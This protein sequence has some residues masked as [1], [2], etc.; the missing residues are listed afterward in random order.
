MRRKSFFWIFLYTVCA[1]VV[2]ILLLSLDPEPTTFF[3]TPLSADASVS[4]EWRIV[5]MLFGIVGVQ[6]ALYL[7]HIK[8]L[9]KR[10]DELE[11]EKKLK[12]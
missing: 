6:T 8:P 7:F 11:E 3:S 4:I 5:I 1:Q 12:K 2:A 10:L 9:L